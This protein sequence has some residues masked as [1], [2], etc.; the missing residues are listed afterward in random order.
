MRTSD[1]CQAGCMAR[2]PCSAPSTVPAFART[3]MTSKPAADLRVAEASKCR[4]APDNWPGL[5]L[6]P[7][8]CESPPFPFPEVIFVV[9]GLIGLACPS[10]IASCPTHQRGVQIRKPMGARPTASLPPATT[11]PKRSR[12]PRPRW[13]GRL[14]PLRWPGRESLARCPEGWRP[15][16]RRAKTYFTSGNWPSLN[17]AKYSYFAVGPTT[18]RFS[19]H[20]PPP[21]SPL[22]ARYSRAF[23]LSQS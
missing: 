22:T 20:G 18:T 9:R 4:V 21:Y 15:S 11:L 6:P 10:R 19:Q 7:P 23:S 12:L 14:P 13:V 3:P 1:T 16:P 5:P 8:L 2:A 17:G